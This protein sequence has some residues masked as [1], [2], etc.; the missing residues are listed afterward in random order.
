M[1]LSL[2]KSP[3]AMHPYANGAFASPIK[4]NA[5]FHA[6]PI[7]YATDYVDARVCLP[8]ILSK[9]IQNHF[10]LSHMS[11]H[12]KKVEQNLQF[13]ENVNILLL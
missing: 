10:G 12:N 5:L 1:I 4:L 3:N 8:I 7:N 2:M 11:H 6:G 9:T 13:V